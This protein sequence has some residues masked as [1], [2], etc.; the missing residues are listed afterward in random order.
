MLVFFLFKWNMRKFNVVIASDHS[1]YI[2]KDKIIKHLNSVNISV[3]DLGPTTERMV[4]YPDYA[5]KVVD[6]LLE[7]IA[8]LGILICGTGIGMSI[9]ANRRSKIRAALCANL[10][11]AERARS[12]NDANILV[13]G[14]KITD[15]KLA[16]SMVDKFLNT[17]FEG[18]RHSTRLSKLS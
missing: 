14:S 15:E 5:A 4:D 11:M 18:G 12:H 13:L 3:E 1:G 6:A 17:P 9:A 10:F 7:E 8:P 16:L 2:L